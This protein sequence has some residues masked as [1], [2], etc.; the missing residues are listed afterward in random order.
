MFV[1][2]GVYRRKTGDKNSKQRCRLFKIIDTDTDVIKLIDTIRIDACIKAG[3]KVLGLNFGG[4]HTIIGYGY[5]KFDFDELDENGN[6]IKD[7]IERNK[8][9]AY[10]IEPISKDIFK[11][12]C[13]D[14]NGNKHTLISDEADD[15]IK[16]GL[17]VGIKKKETGIYRANKAIKRAVTSINEIECIEADF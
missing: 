3:A 17:V 15:L 1:L 7:E 13:V 2:L 14:Y 10:E 6:S 8:F 4:E 12:K 9:I 5:S 11:I 16:D